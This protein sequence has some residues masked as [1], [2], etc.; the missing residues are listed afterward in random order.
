MYT[1]IEFWTP[2]KGEAQQT[3]SYS[4]G[5]RDE[6]MSSYHYILHQAAVSEHYKHGALVIDGDG[7]YL[8]RESFTHEPPVPESEP[9]E[10][11]PEEE[12]V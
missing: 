11:I 5:T 6:A 1:V 3:I 9:E 8:A 7:K 10:E 12:T 4:K 2:N